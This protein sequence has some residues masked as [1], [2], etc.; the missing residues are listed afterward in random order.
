[1]IF[2]DYNIKKIETNIKKNNKVP[3][4]S[5][6]IIVLCFVYLYI[7]NKN[8][9]FYPLTIIYFASTRIMIKLSDKRVLNRVDEFNKEII[10]TKPII[11]INDN[12]TITVIKNNSSVFIENISSLDVKNYYKK[13]NVTHVKCEV[14]DENS[15]LISNV[16]SFSNYM[17]HSNVFLQY[18]KLLIYINRSKNYSNNIVKYLLSSNEMDNP[19]LLFDEIANSTLFVPFKFKNINFNVVSDLN[20]SK[21]SVFDFYKSENNEIL[22]YTSYEEYQNMIY[23]HSYLYLISFKDL[24]DY[25]GV[26]YRENTVQ[27]NLLVKNYN[28]KFIL[29][30]D[31]NNI[32]FSYEHFLAIYKQM[33]ETIHDK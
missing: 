1:M 16:Y 17:S 3:Y 9:M 6:I 5:I 18:L 26:I 33:E 31:S 14:Y 32:K 30:I 24:M 13:S 25:F 4:F 23:S 28:L 12:A 7:N 15:N 22:L 11:K 29:N 19:S 21:S 20:N 10:E 27:N 2:G 8:N